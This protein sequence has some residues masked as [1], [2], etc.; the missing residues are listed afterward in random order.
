MRACGS[1]KWLSTAHSRVARSTD[2]CENTWSSTCRLCSD[3]N[4]S[5]AACLAGSVPKA[6]TQV[7][8]M[9][10]SILGS[11]RW[12][13]RRPGP[14]G[15]A[16][17]FV[18]SFNNRS[19][20]WT[21]KTHSA[22]Q[23][24]VWSGL[25]TRA[26]WCQPLCA[27]RPPAAN[28]LH[29]PLLLSKAPGLSSRRRRSSL[30][31]PTFARQ[32]PCACSPIAFK[33]SIDDTPHT[34]PRIVSSARVR[35]SQDGEQVGD[36]DEEMSMHQASDQLRSQVARNHDC[37]ARGGCVW[38]PPPPPARPVSRTGACSTRGP[39]KQCRS[40]IVLPLP[41]PPASTHPSS[42]YGPRLAR[43]VT[44]GWCGLHLHRLHL[45]GLRACI[46]QHRRAQQRSRGQQHRMSHRGGV[47]PAPAA[48]SVA[49]AAQS[50]WVG[51]P[52]RPAAAP[53]LK[54]R[55]LVHAKK[56]LHP[57]CPG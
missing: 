19:R 31:N 12:S 3:S 6:L 57:S 45:L 32:A 17:F 9:A 47:T 25:T 30:H 39:A 28:P 46:T 24:G 36:D 2:P 5:H 8:S 51:R 4:S 38:P 22:R 53:V 34:F 54:F 16:P 37:V 18:A 1:H 27:A 26:Q 55:R 13:R 23:A 7:E 35:K 40:P 49:A 29:G 20:M 52:V 50:C 44:V 48:L 41:R 15:S 10:A 21:V 33:G 11:V 14:C 56:N 42:H 43:V